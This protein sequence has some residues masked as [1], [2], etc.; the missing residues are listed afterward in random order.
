MSK[1]VSCHQSR[2]EHSFV[3][4]LSSSEERL[5]GLCDSG[6]FALGALVLNRAVRIIES[7]VSS[8]FVVLDRA[9]LDIAIHHLDGYSKDE[10]C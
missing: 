5:F 9:D 7:L 10:S 2:I 8:P 3:L 4:C 1:F 6:F